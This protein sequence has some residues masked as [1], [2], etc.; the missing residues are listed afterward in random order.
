MQI[1]VFPPLRM[2]E[3][4]L[5]GLGV[6]TNMADMIEYFDETQEEPVTG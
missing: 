3:E 6:D 1:P 2:L 5:V 4:F